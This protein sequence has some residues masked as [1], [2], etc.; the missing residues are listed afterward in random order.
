[1]RDQMTK[2]AGLSKDF[3]RSHGYFTENMWHIE[4]V[5]FLC[6]EKNYPFLSDAEAMQVFYFASSNFEGEYGLNWKK[7]AMALDSYMERKNLLTN[8]EC[9]A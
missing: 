1:M 4:D 9:A 7:L 6:S 8:L 3:L 5:H 2:L